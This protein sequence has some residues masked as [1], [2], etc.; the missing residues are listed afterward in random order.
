MPVITKEFALNMK[1]DDEIRDITKKM[2]DTLSEI[3]MDDGVITIFVKHTTASVMIFEDEPGL[4]SDTKTI[5]KKLVPEDKKWS[6]NTLN[7]GEDNAHSHLRAQIQ[8]QS[9]AIPFLNKK[10]TLGTWQHI[11]IIDFDTQSRERNI[12]FQIMGE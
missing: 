2:S 9:L 6:H 8:G 12:V 1:G 11:V 3:D 7:A 10:L 4:R 5:W